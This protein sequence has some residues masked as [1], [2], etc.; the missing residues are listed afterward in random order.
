[1]I[2][3]TSYGAYIPRYRLNRMMIYN[4]IGW[5][6]SGNISLSKGEKAV[7]G[8][9]EDSVTM[10]VGAGIDALKGLNREN[11]DAVNFAS[12]CMPFKERLNA[13]IIKEA[14]GL[15]DQIAVSDFSSG[16]KAGTTAVLHAIDAVTSGR[17]K[18][19]LVCASD[20]RLGKP[21]SAQ[22]MIF[23][24]AAAALTIGSENVIAECIGSY[25]TAHDFVDHYRGEFAKFDRQW[26]DRWIRDSGIT[27]LIPEAING[28]LESNNMQI[29]D[30]SKV[31]YPCHYAAARRQLNKQ[32]G[33]AP[34]AEQNNLQTEIGESGTSHAVL[35]LVKALEEAKPGDKILVVSFG[36]GCDVLAFQVTDQIT[37]LSPRNGVSKAL[38]NRTELDNY[39]KYLVW[40][41]ILP[42][43]KGLRSEED[44]WTRWSALWRKRKEVLGLFGSKCTKCGTVQY[45]PQRICINAECGATDE[46]EA[47]QFSDKKGYISSYTGDNLA[48]SV[49]P[50]AVYGQIEFEGGGKYMFD[51]TDCDMDSLDTGMPVAMSFR[52][53][54]HDAKRDISGYFWKAVPQLEEN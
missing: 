15:K 22:E 41:D 21:G 3:I 28:F 46:M 54:Y 19:T 10:A 12:T 32:F 2:G 24:D 8:F 42:A 48:P 9:D 13:G 26:E 27:Q 11:F 45:P 49:N 6:A 7:A 37:N 29:G 18:N 23:G 33:I 31:V 20:I 38:A 34:E 53:R 14:L 36:S 44:L 50:P 17:S 47:Y 16:I 25:C 52:R 43:E 51:L 40:R 30:F 5:M 1:M 35:M 4:A 39:T